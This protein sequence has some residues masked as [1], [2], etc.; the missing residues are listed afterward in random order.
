MPSVWTR[1]WRR[2]VPEHLRA[3]VFDPTV[4]DLEVRRAVRLQAGPRAVGRLAANLAWASSVT[5][6]ALQCLFLRSSA[7]A[8][9]APP[10]AQGDSAMVIWGRDLRLAFRRIRHEPAFA[11]FAVATLALG[12][13]ANVAVFSFVNAFLVAPLD[14]PGSDRLVRV[15]GY[16]QASVCDVV[17]YPNYADLRDGAPDLDLAAHIVTD[18]MVGPDE[19][20]E[21]REVELVTGNYFRVMQVKP[22]IGRVFD[23]SDDVTELAHPVVLLSEGYWRGRAGARADIVGQTILLNNAPYEVV[24]VVP[25]SFRGTQNGMAVDL[26]API[27]QQQQLRPR[28]QTLQARGW[29]WLRLIGRIAP[30][31]S[32]VKVQASLDRAAADLAQRFPARRDSVRYVASKATSLEEGER[33]TLV[34]YASMTLAL[35]GLLLVVTCANLAGLMQSRA[36]GRRRELAIRQSLGAARGRLL[37]EW[38]TECLTI[39]MLGGAAG[40]LVARVLAAGIEQLPGGIL[41]RMDQGNLLLDWRVVIF[42]IAMSLVAALLVGLPAAR[43]ATALGVADVLKDETGTTS[44]GRRGLRLR[45]LTVLVQVVAAAVLLVG[46]GLLVASLRN[47]RGFDTGFRTDHLAGMWVDLKRAHIP[48][49]GAEA[50]T[51]AMLERV[52]AVPGVL[53]SAI[54]A[55]VPLTD[56]RDAIGFR[57][58][59][60][61]PDDGKSTVAIDINVVGATYFSTME[62]GFVR[63]RVWAPGEP[64]L[65]VNETAAK[66]F[67]P[68]KDPIGQPVEVVGQATLPVAG[69]VRDSAYYQVGESSRPFVFLPAEVAKPSSYAVLTRTSIDPE[70]ALAHIT[71]AVKAVDG[72]VRPED[73]STFEAMRESQL[74]PRRILA[75]G[76]SAFGLV[77]LALTAI[78]LFGVVST[79]VAMRTREIGIRMALGARPDGVL[80]A[81]L[82]E[83][84]GLVLI[85]ASV[86][87]IAAYAAAGTLRQWLFGVSRFDA[88]IYLTVAVVLIAMT[89]IAAGVPARRAACIDPVKA[90]RS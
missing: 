47:L 67:W 10:Q 31:A 53:S 21:S 39:A 66:R 24:G 28:S 62:I 32:F 65:V 20:G 22:M 70:D 54:V 30:Q 15:C 58:P 64:G 88:A 76:T 90:L 5:I 8:I 85:G 77:A 51:A 35:T 42:A 83:S 7:H 84:A 13:G 60:Y 16:T 6:A 9:V 72:R 41:P 14:V 68:G 56:N 12:L 4:H 52:R 63:G 79:S 34:P 86:G 44:G 23:T 50:F 71:A 80:V 57:I 11:M 49:E 38:L 18:V 25:A 59:G 26:W 1:A 61:V 89:L 69:V 29:G 3:R 81:V 48:A 45:R 2:L 74:A 36:I 87:L 46:S 75:W 33:A 19:T 37:A 55:N 40:L 78:G 73:V 17:S 82:R 27:A 43:R